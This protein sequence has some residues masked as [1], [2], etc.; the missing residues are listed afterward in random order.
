VKPS[1]DSA[2][3]DLLE[4]TRLD[5]CPDDDSVMEPFRVA[6]RSHGRTDTGRVRA[7]NEDRFLI[8]ELAPGGRLA[9]HL[10]AVADGMGGHAG[11]QRASGL[12]LEA[13]ENSLRDSLLHGQCPLPEDGNGLL[14]KLQESVLAAD[15]R[16]HGQARENPELH[17]MGSTL[18]AACLWQQELFIAQVGD[19]RCY[20]IRNGALQRLTRDQTMVEEMLR[21]GVLKPAEAAR[22][23]W[24]HVITNAVGGVEAGGQPE[25]GRVAVQPGDAILLCSDGLTEMVS[26]QEI[27]A[28]AQAGSDPER[29]CERLVNLANERGGR[30]NI[31]VIVATIERPGP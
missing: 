5:L 22:H 24:R 12:T 8:A 7:V 13:L 14:R 1:S 20:L 21:A 9:L 2:I 16:V 27:L 17:G 29:L 10:F 6:V 11:G 18:T 15:A 30:D 26:E 28:E 23:P 31:T 19:S 3:L 4:D 25:L